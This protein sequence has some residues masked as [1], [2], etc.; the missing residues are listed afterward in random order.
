MNS[1]R[2][3]CV[4]G[5]SS[6]EVEKSMNAFETEKIKSPR[7]APFMEVATLNVK[8]DA[9]RRDIAMEIKIFRKYICPCPNGL[10]LHK[11]KKK[12]TTDW[13]R[14]HSGCVN[15]CTRSPILKTSPYPCRKFSRE[16]KVM[17]ASSLTQEVLITRNEYITRNGIASDLCLLSHKFIGGK[18][19]SKDDEG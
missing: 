3:R 2:I 9:I 18:Y 19:N 1:K 8:I 5:F 13:I 15:V 14:N 4:R 10:L 17:I 16:R 12:F 11:L 6:P 7:I